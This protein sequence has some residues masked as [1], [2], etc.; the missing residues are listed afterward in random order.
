MSEVFSG[1][2][3][4]DWVIWNGNHGLVTTAALGEIDGQG[5]QMDGEY[6]P[7]GFAQSSGVSPSSWAVLPHSFHRSAGLDVGADI[8]ADIGGGDAREHGKSALANQ[9]TVR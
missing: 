4:Q 5:T 8:G 3:D 6:A 1:A 7:H 2:G 9:S